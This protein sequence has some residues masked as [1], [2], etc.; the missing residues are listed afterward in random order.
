MTMTQYE[1]L[2]VET[3]EFLDVCALLTGRRQ[4]F[5]VVIILTRDLNVSRRIYSII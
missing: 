3:G 5:T 1:V 4:V 2:G